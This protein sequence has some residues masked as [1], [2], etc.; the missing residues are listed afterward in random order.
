MKS[1]AESWENRV[2]V[3]RDE[4]PPCFSIHRCLWVTHF[5]AVKEAN[6]MLGLPKGPSFIPRGIAHKMLLAESM[7]LFPPAWSLS[8]GSP[9]QCLTLLGFLWVAAITAG[10]KP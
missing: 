2:N 4:A 7:W 3:C 5:V 9:W 10:D 8:P 6:S 1:K